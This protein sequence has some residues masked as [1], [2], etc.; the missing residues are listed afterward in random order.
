MPFEQGEAI[1]F[2]QPDAPIH[3]FCLACVS[4]A[5]RLP[6]SLGH[7]QY[8]MSAEHT[9]LREPIY[10]R[11]LLLSG[12]KRNAVLE[13][14]EVKRYGIDSYGDADYVSVYGMRPDD[15]HAK[16]VR[17]MGRTAVECTRDVLAHAIG[18]D[19]ADVAARA[20]Y[21]ARALVVDLFAG[22][23]NTLYWLMRH[24]PGAKG[25]GFE[26]DAGVFRLTHQNLAALALPIEILNTDY[27]SGMT[28]VSVAADQMLIAFIAP[29]WGDALEKSSGLDLRRTNPPIVEVVNFLFNAFTQS[30]I[31]CVVQ[32]SEVVS[33][34]SLVELKT[35]FDW[36]TLQVYA[37]NAPGQNHGI[38]LGSKRWVPKAAA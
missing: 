4:A 23:G 8:G 15:W 13:P 21:T 7:L 28:D 10:D 5:R 14:W 35:C 26:L 16:G 2:G 36:S 3:G 20:P 32:V 19:V 6:Y 9:S 25:L 38:L 29:P 34:D 1:P 11:Q 31:L 22:S 37:M 27:R 33:A 17:L 24:L 30:P 12:A 18:R